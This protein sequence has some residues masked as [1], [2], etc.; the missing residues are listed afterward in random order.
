MKRGIL[1]TLSVL[2]GVGTGIVATKKIMEREIS[3]HQ[4]LS[5]KHMG[6]FLLMNQWVKINQEGKRIADYFVE[7]NYYSIAVYGMSYVGETLVNELKDSEVKVLYG[8][9]KAADN[10]YSELD[11]VSPE[12]KMCE[13]DAV[14]VT[15]IAF[16]DEIEEQ[17]RKRIN[18]PIISLED[19]VYEM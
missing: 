5:D 3:K 8:I 19:I 14:V 1:S 18:C 6:L 15:S 16:F 10:I 4:K 9:D 2:A 7:N 17:L 11:I 12:D 13:V